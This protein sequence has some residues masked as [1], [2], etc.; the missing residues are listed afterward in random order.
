MGASDQQCHLLEG[1]FAI[2]VQA[3]LGFMCVTTLVVKRQTEQPRRPWTIWFLDAMKQG[4]GASLGH[5]GNI[6]LSAIIA[7]SEETGDECQWYCLSFLMDA[8][9][10][11]FFN[12]MFFLCFESFIRTRPQY[13]FLK[14]GHYGNPPKFS[15]F[16]AQ[17]LVWLLI[18]S[19]GKSITIFLQI[20]FSGNLNAV[21]NNIFYFVRRDPKIELVLVM[22]VIPVFVN[23]LQFWLTDSY[24]KR[25]DEAGRGHAHEALRQ[26][27]D[28]DESGIPRE[29]ITIVHEPTKLWMQTFQPVLFSL[30][31]L[32][33][34]Y[35]IYHV[36]IYHECD[37]VTSTHEPHRNE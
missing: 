33:P 11:L 9:F 7:S 29:V 20:C 4:I 18:V 23:A 31:Y 2:M 28:D 21:L 10:G 22:I 26:M 3:F 17:L 19:I 30:Y 8:T 5:F 36:F 14:F 34:M 35:T 12:I 13:S 32:L 24:L 25:D 6:I 16:A 1:G 37:A 15:Y 27:D